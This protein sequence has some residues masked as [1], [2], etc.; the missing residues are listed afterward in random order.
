MNV[1]ERHP[2]GQ[3]IYT[4]G[5]LK[6]DSRAGASIQSH[7]EDNTIR[8]SPKLRELDGSRADSRQ[9]YLVQFVQ[10]TKPLL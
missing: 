7:A 6:F 8:V 1:I 3:A 10:R 5:N 9:S 4:S 2:F